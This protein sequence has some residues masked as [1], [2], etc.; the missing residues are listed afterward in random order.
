[1][2]RINV[3]TSQQTLDV[4]VT[5]DK[6]SAGPGDNVT[7][8]IVT[9]D[10]T[11]KPVSADVSLAVVDKAV[12]ALAPSNSA[13]ILDS[14][15]PEQGLGVQT[16]L[17]LVASA[18]DFNAQYRQ[19]IPEGGG[20]GGGG[21]DESLGIITV[22]QDFKDT[23]FFQ[24]QVT[25]DANGQAQVT[26][27]LPENLT[28]WAADARAATADGRVGQATRNWSAPSRS[29][30]SCRRRASLSPATRRAWAR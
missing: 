7:Y 16:A 17:G 25:T 8:T 23:A 4:K 3:D 14:F 6:K 13:P 5:T 9:K 20:S 30:W 19:S 18:D 26:V 21:G 27:K 15:Y 24:A 11:G 28:T 2:A 10:Q 29:S 12:L 22:R 1:M